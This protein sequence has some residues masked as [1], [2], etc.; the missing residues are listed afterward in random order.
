MSHVDEGM[1]HAYL[2]GELPAGERSALEAHVAQCEACRARVHEERAL[3]ERASTLLSAVR[4]LERPAPPFEQIRRPPKRSPWRV[5]TSFAWAASIALALGLGYYLHDVGAYRAAVPEEAAPLAS[6]R[7]SPAADKASA[8]APEQKRPATA[9]PGR[10]DVAARQPDARRDVAPSGRAATGA[11]AGAGADAG[12]IDSNAL[13]VATAPTLKVTAPRA[14]ADSVGIVVDGVA[15]PA[16]APLMEQRVTERM[17]SAHM[18]PRI[19]RET[20]RNILGEDP[21]GLPDLTTRTFRRSPERDGVVVVEQELD[22]RTMIQIFQENAR[23]RNSRIDSLVAGNSFYR[24]NG[25]QRADRLAR[26]VGKLR[27]EIGGPVSVDSLNRLLD[28][29][30]PLP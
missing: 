28:L 16:P 10:R 3:V 8:G 2:D 15:A 11:G 6:V 25:P 23:A 22:S 7:E 14:A 26:F 24:S 9:A 17:P 5:R 4:P 1:L 29:V 18:W 12:R 27:V 21:V 19:D 30:R 20:A 13:K